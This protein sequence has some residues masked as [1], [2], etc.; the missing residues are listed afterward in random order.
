MS[1]TDI[2]GLRLPYGLLKDDLHLAA[3]GAQ[4]LGPQSL[5]LA[6]VEANGATAPFESQQRES[7][8]RLARATFSDHP[9]GMPFAH[10][11]RDSVDRL[12]VVDGSPQ[13][14]RLHREPHPHVLR[15]HQGGCVR[16]SFHRFA[17]RL[18]RQQSPGIGMGRLVEDRLDRPRLHDLAVLH[19]VDPL[20]HLSHDVEVVGDEKHCHLELAL[21]LAQEGE[22]LGLDGH[23]ERGSRLVGDQEIRLIGKCHRNHHP[24]ALPAGELMWIGAQ[25]R[26]GVCDAD[27]AQQLQHPDPRGGGVHPPM[28][29]KHLGN[30]L[31]HRVQRIERGH[32]LLENHGNLVAPHRLQ[33]SEIGAQ[34]LTVAPANRPAARM[35]GEGIGKELQDREGGYRLSGS[36]LADEGNRLGGSDRQRGAL[37]CHHRLAGRS[38]LHHRGW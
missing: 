5:E 24:L 28:E 8:R 35:V 2:R 4:R 10:R 34:Q 19:H 1:P 38:E 26:L 21:K 7:Q 11:H 31:F 15:R 37:D 29:S 27:E 13:N 25:A 20:G 18:R 32:R 33:G 30:L 17:A 16:R 6:A 23:V 9:D 22:N 3:Q 12:D 36:A 14:P